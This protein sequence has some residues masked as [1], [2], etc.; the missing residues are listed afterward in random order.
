MRT[1]RRN[2]SGPTKARIRNAPG[3]HPLEDVRVGARARRQAVFPR[4]AGRFL[5]VALEEQPGVVDLEDVDLVQ[6]PVHGG[7][8]RDRVHPVERVGEVDDALLLADRGDRLGERHAA[9][10]LLA[11]EEADHLAL[12]VRLHLLAGNHDQVATARPRDRL[13]GAAEHVVIRD[14]DRPEPFG[15]GVVEQ[16][17]HLDRAVVRPRR[18]HVQV[19]DDPGP[20]GERL[21]VPL[22]RT[23]PAGEAAIHLVE[24]LRHRREA[25]LFGTG[26]RFTSAA[27]S[28]RVVLDEPR[29]RRSRQL[30]LLE[31]AG[32]IGKGR[33]G[34]SRLEPEPCRSGRCGD[35][36]RSLGEDGRAGLRPAPGANVH[37]VAQHERDS[38]SGRQRFR[39]DEDGVPSGEVA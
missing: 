16:F 4:E 2:S 10:D 33:T 26:A 23:P 29:D 35:D 19:G 38:G 39:P 8:E 6:V 20:V 1:E 3:A 21:D 25:L 36:D 28:Q 18:V 22:A 11:Q 30:G 32:R 31:D 15:F 27:L 7:R 17:V 37:P 24:I 5:V 13:L 34:G 9:G 14:R 12:V